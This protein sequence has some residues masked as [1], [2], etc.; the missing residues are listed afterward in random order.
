M[1]IDIITLH[2][3]FNYGSVLQ[4]YATQKVF[5]DM[6]YDVKVID[7]IP[8]NWQISKRM[9]LKSSVKRNFLKDVIYRIFRGVSII[10]KSRNFGGFLKRNLNLTKKYMSFEKLQKNPPL[11]DVYCTGS[12]QVWNT[13]YCG[14]DKAFFLRFAPKG[15][16]RIAFAASFGMTEL[17]DDQRSVISEYLTDYDS[18]SLREN[19]AVDLVNSLGIDAI[20]II[21]P[22]L[23][24]SG[25]EWRK[26]A[27]KRLVKEKY[28]I[29]MLLY[30]EDNNATEIA[31]KIADEK[32]LKLIKISWDLKKPPLVD[33]LFTHRPPDEF[34]S[35]FYHA[36]YVV[37]N[38]FHG[39]A[40]SINFGKQFT[41][42]KRNEYNSRI[43]S[44]LSLTGLE[45][46]MVDST[47]DG[48]DYNAK[49]D[50]ESVNEVLERE[51]Q[52][53]KNFIVESLK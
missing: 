33:K 44:L 11:A 26:L 21:D 19:S 3:V 37:T 46:R 12:D 53:A 17:P 13:D 9:F 25:D 31:R 51:R 7:Y 2:R 30:S 10:I 42:C 52:K 28:L 40:F 23:Q 47:L 35:L 32:G 34:L 48:V 49:I 39:L 38:S 41:I 6:G 14:V 45:D 29:L 1:K 50:Y 15:A 4:T 43:E 22:T 27:S 18:I 36:D 20:E 8:R 5:S 24:I 16:K